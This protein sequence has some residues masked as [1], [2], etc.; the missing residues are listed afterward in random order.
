MKG[1]N[2]E[3]L[4]L[5]NRIAIVAII[6]VALVFGTVPHS[7]DR[8]ADSR[9]TLDSMLASANFNT[10]D[11]S[12][13][14]NP[15]VPVVGDADDNSNT[16]TNNSNATENAE[17]KKAAEEAAKAKEAAELNQ[18]LA[19]LFSGTSDVKSLHASLLQRHNDRVA[20]A[21][22][23]DNADSGNSSTNYY[24]RST[25]RSSSNSSAQNS[26]NT[27]NSASS[28]SSTANRPS[29]NPSRKINYDEV[30]YIDD[31]YEAIDSQ[32]QRF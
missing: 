32:R 11:F 4:V 7:S 8:K 28:N 23:N 15:E 10:V 2:I 9:N 12:P 30:I 22:Q 14:I 31:N 25:A 13:L 24:S 3:K 5:F 26:S 20:R 1:K 29:Q 27:N 19:G 6:L 17:A 18:L 16:S 21:N